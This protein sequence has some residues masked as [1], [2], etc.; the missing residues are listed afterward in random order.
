MRFISWETLHNGRRSTGMISK[1]GKRKLEFQGKTY[2]WHIKEG[3][4][5]NPQLHIAS[6][7]KT[8][9]LTCGFDREIG[10]GTRYIK[11]LLTRYLTDKD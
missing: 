7:D 4:D 9:Y 3:Q 10:V 6:E 5:K 11:E 1:K 8:F 2:Y